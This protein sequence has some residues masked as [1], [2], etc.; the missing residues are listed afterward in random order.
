MK[1]VVQIIQFADSKALLRIPRMMT[2]LPDGIAYIFQRIQGYGEIEKGVGSDDAVIYHFHPVDDEEGQTDTAQKRITVPTVDHTRGGELSPGVF[3][4]QDGQTGGNQHQYIRYEKGGASVSVAHV[5]KS[6]DIAETDG[7][8]QHG[9]QR[10]EIAAEH[11]SLVPI[12]EFLRPDRVVQIL[13]MVME[14]RQ[15]RYLTPTLF[16][17]G[18]EAEFKGDLSRLGRLGTLR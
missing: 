2:S 10:V 7:T 5:R 4:A 3:H 6:P 13:M 11:I 18:V 17:P 8:G 14:L 9:N 15:F 12:D 16:I 1:R